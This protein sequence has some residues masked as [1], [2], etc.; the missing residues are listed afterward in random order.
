MEFFTANILMQL[1]NSFSK[2]VYNWLVSVN[3]LDTNQTGLL[4]CNKQQHLLLTYYTVC[5]V[6]RGDFG[7]W[8]FFL[9]NC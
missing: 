4:D 1:P 5:T 2:T 6:V 7:N 9:F 3:D 8:K